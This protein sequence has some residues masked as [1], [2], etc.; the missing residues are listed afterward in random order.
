M[1]AYAHGSFGEPG[2]VHDIDVPHPAAH[3]VRIRVV[4]ASVNPV[5]WKIS[6]G[7]LKDFIEHRFPLIS[8]QDF[9]GIVDAVGV[10]VRDLKEGDEVFGSHGQQFIGRGTHAE[11]VIANT[12][13][14]A[15]KPVTLAGPQAASIPHA[16]VCGLMCVD[17]VEAGPGDTILI[18]GA[19]GGVG[20]FAVQIAVA[21]GARVIAVART[22]NHEYLRKLGAAIT[23]DYERGDL[24]ESVRETSGGSLDGLIHL[25][26]DADTLR[27]LSA[28]VPNGGM[29]ASP[30]VAPM[31]DPRIRGTRIATQVTRE[32]LEQLVS[33]IADG[34]LVL[35]EIRTFKLDEARAAFQ[36][37]EAGHVRG[38]LVLTT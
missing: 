23:L 18:V 24:V 4:A 31:D 20:S 38:K 2:S 12:M 37:S 32:R 25:A 5:D 34:T 30:V 11:Y 14:V 27:A 9:A 29:V 10:D 3:E 8:G 6:K 17:A 13:A 19:A 26:G 16:G 15:P 35:P 28:L 33:W 36:E 22:V 7:Y 21:R 1:R